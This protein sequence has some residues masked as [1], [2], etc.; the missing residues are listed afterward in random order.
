MDIIRDLVTDD[1]LAGEIHPD[2]VKLSKADKRAR[3]TYAIP[4]TVLADE[5]G[6]RKTVWYPV[7]ELPYPCPG[8][9]RRV[10]VEVVAD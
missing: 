4:R 3:G 7:D 5:F 9:I 1:Y 10:L 2:L 8:E 6:N